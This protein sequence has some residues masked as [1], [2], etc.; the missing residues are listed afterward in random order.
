MMS[1]LSSLSD[2]STMYTLVKFQLVKNGIKVTKYML[3]F[4]YLLYSLLKYI[5]WAK[6]G[7]VYISRDEPAL[8]VEQQHG[9]FV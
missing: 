9:K 8:C 1:I 5:Y 6:S 3:F 4:Q 7:I 2:R